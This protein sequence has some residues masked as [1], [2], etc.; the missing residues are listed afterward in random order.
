MDKPVNSKLPQ[1][2]ARFLCPKYWG[3]WLGIGLARLL[4]YLPYTRKRKLGKWIGRLLYQFGRNRRTISQR[5]LTLAFPDKSSTEIEALNRQHFES[6]GIGF[7]ETLMVWWGDHRKHGKNCFE[8]QLVTFQGL[9]NLKAAQATNRGILLLVPHFTHIDLTGL[10]ISFLINCRPIYRPHDNPV[11]EY[12]IKKGRTIAHE[13]DRAVQPISNRDTRTMLRALRK[14]EAFFFLPDQKYTAKGHL[15]V[16]FFNHLAPS[17]PATSKL[18]KM[19]NALVVPCFTRRDETGH[20]T[21]T[22]LPAL[23]HFPSGDDYQDTLRLHHLYESE[24][25]QNI[26]QYLWV[27]DRW[28]LKDKPKDYLPPSEALFQK[29]NSTHP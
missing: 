23:D 11:M 25:R 15:D 10:F 1:F 2:Q 19:T 28:N 5:N 6:L 12:F 16:P 4:V 24:I 17:N 8:R 21:V 20:Y 26:P 14:G 29:E 22:F 13:S 9:E 18:A 3:V 7:M 27:H